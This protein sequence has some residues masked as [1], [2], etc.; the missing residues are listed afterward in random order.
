MEPG[1]AAGEGVAPREESPEASRQALRELRVL[2][3]SSLVFGQTRDPAAVGQHIIA[4]MEKLLPYRRGSIW[5]RQEG[6]SDLTL[7]AHSDLDMTPAD[8]EEEL[9]RVRKLVPRL[10]EGFCGWVALHGKP[11]RSGDVQRDPRYVDADPSIKS[12]LCVPL[13]VEGRVLGSINAESNQADAFTEHDEQLLHTL[14]NQAVIAI[15]NARLIQE[16][17]WDI[18]ERKRAEEASQRHLE[19]NQQFLE[20]TLDGYILVDRSGQIMDVNP[21]YCALMGYEHEELLRMNLRELKYD[22]GKRE[23]GP[24]IDMTLREGR[25]R[26][27]TTHRTKDGGEVQLEASTVAL[28]G[29]EQPLLAAFLR[30]VTERK[31]GEEELKELGRQLRALL[32]KLRRAREEERVRVSREIHDELGQLLT[33]LKMDVR[34]LERKLSEPSLPTA[35]NPLLD[36]AVAASA[37]A[38]EAIL[39]VQKIAAELRPAT[40]FELGLVSA[41]R[42]EARRFGERAGVDCTF[43]APEPRPVVPPEVASE[44]FY[45]CQEALTNVARHAKASRVEISLQLAADTLVLEVR[46]DGTGMT[47]VATHSPRALG[48]I[49]MRERAVQ[50]G[51]TI[52]FL[53]AEPQ[54]TRVRVALPAA[55]CTKG[56][57]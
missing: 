32:T 11:I 2:Y 43:T 34:W 13:L 14:A 46:D 44:L 37:L 18:A 42:E 21:A 50:C 8:L 7:L 29:D 49:G 5:L 3:Q 10:G 56:E 20:A 15:E 54:G 35:L 25:G 36:R 12:E 27:E 22:G 45:I 28:R 23:V 4:T 31:K 47:G 53:R 26:F 30:D 17:E 6:T 48:L 57:E 41:L 9:V 1:E 24:R 55:G 40:I 19:Q 51:G 33:G 52:S 39:A 16:L 38:D